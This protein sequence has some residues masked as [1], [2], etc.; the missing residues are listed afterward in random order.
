[1]GLR[2][3]DLDPL[4]PFAPR[5]GL[6]LELD[7]AALPARA[8]APAAAAPVEAP[9]A[10]RPEPVE[11]P[12][13]TPRRA[14]ELARHGDPPPF[15]L[16][17][18]Y[19]I[20]VVRRNRALRQRLPELR[21][22]KDQAQADLE[23]A[24][25][26][27][28]RALHA[29]R[30]HPRAPELGSALR[31]ANAA[32]KLTADHDA[33]LERAREEARDQ[34]AETV[35]SIA[36]AT[37]AVRPLSERA[38]ELRAQVV[39]YQQDFEAASRA[40]RDATAELDAL[41]KSKSPDANRRIELEAGRTLRRGEADAAVAEIEARTPELSEVEA[42]ILEIER[43]S[44][45]AKKVIED[46]ASALVRTEARIAKEAADGREKYERALVELAD[47]AVR[48]R[49]D[50]AI[51]KPAAKLARLRYD[52]WAANVR[53]LE[54]HEIALTL[55]HPT[56]LKRGWAQLA[57]LGLGALGWLVWLVT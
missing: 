31:R 21:R 28:G 56:S 40:I 36:H 11:E 2:D 37:E 46:V 50:H 54:A 33:E 25:L 34:T 23:V 17:G 44:A 16:E 19:A 18:W 24:T 42:K 4:G 45:K 57:V 13:G 5:G 6:E 12:E 55:R 32:Q 52:T 10:R 1:M 20:D 49:I 7:D 30:D 47:E 35:A 38:R 48:L 15:V 53:E 41:A 39:V 43:A 22:V 51:A 26:E 27:L 9:K 14:L 3:S 29:E 8:P